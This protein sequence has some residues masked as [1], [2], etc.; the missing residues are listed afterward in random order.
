MK[1]KKMSGG[2]KMI[3][4]AGMTA[5]GAGAYYLLGPDAKMHQKKAS[6]LV[7]KMKKEMEGEIKKAENEWKSV[8]GKM[9]KKT[10]KVSLGRSHTGEAKK[11]NVK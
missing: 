11:K 6:T 3:V 1:N 8:S 7:K 5:L 2:K 10:A 9:V 4:G